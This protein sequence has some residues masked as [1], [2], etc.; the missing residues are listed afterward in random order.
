MPPEIILPNIRKLFI[1]DEG[2]TIYD[3]D[4]SGADAQVVAW[5]AEDDDLKEAFRKGLDVHSKNA[6]DMW[7]TAFTQLA[8]TTKEAGPKHRKRQETKVGVHATNYG[9]SAAALAKA[10][11][12]TV[13]ESDKFQKRWFQIHPKIRENFHRK[14]Q[15]RLDANRTVTNA[16]G[17]SRIFFDRPADCFTN[18][19]AW[20]PQSTVALVTFD[21]A[22]QLEERME[23]I[24]MLLQVHDS[25]VFQRKTALGMDVP[26]LKKNLEVVVPY[27]DELII[28]WGVKAS[29]VSWGDCKSLG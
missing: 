8:G 28:P 16:F 29:T 2:Y 12:W 21:G 23:G 10:L 11:G 20:I 14:T 1:P 7:G 9:G 19:L 18:A 13:H 6:E 3:A 5:E 25:I 24:E 17:Y 4:L 27:E 26:L 22:L 15:S